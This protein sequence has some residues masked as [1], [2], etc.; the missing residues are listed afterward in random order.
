[1]R[2]IPFGQPLHDLSSIEST[3]RRAQAVA[4]LHESEVDN[5]FD[6]TDSFIF[7]LHASLADLNAYTS[8]IVHVVYQHPDV[9]LRATIVD[10]PGQYPI[11]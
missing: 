6:Y 9:P 8:H 10:L 2:R 4:F 3:I 1:M 5:I 11:E 7:E